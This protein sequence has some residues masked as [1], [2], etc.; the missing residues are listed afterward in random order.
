[1]D[2][3][4]IMAVKNLARTQINVLSTKYYQLVLAIAATVSLIVLLFWRFSTWYYD[5][6]FITYRYAWNLI[7]GL[8]FVYN[9]NERVLSTTTPFF[10][11]LL[12]GFG[13]IWSD[14]PKIASLIGSLCAGLSGFLFW[15]ITRK[16][17]MEIAGWAGLVLIPVFPL[18]TSTI[19]SETPL[20]IA[21][22]LATIDAYI[23]GR[24]RWTAIAAA[25]LILV[26]PDGVLLPLL[27][28]IHFVIWK[29]E[30]LPWQSVGLFVLITALWFGFAWIY[31]GSP[32]PDTLMAKQQQGVMT[33]S[34][35]FAPGLLTIARPYAKSWFYLLEA[36]FALIGLGWL[37]F[38]HQQPLILVAW[39][40]AY[41]LAY[42]LLGVTRYFW[43]YAPLVPAFILMVGSGFQAIYELA[44]YAFRKSR[45]ATFHFESILFIILAVIWVFQGIS[46]YNQSL[47]TDKRVNLYRS[48]GEWLRNNTGQ[49]TRVGAVE[50]GIIG[51][52]AERP[53]V[54]FAGLIQPDV[55]LQMRPDTTYQD[56][57]RWAIR[58][59][60]PDYLAL[61]PV[62]FPDLMKDYVDK[63]CSMLRYFK[64]QDYQSNQDM[65][66]YR[67]H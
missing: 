49:N 5:D 39:A 24:Y 32:L 13:Y 62:I 6:P 4:W 7:H 48:V 38:R 50:V 53:M 61:N 17:K 3:F 11:L 60:K 54:D 35:Q 31:F 47:A 59:Y 8:G 46:T 22:V 30:R 36:F 20:Y 63:R 55:A 27:L 34:Q 15:D 2:Q 37:L 57:A 14:L 9:P 19:S 56:T 66:V 29:K 52:Y 33:I 12:A 42:T 26:R 41:F 21:L 43:Y 10:T 51:Y 1:M 58:Q 23:H 44:I 45:F 25:I 18:I 40:F 28:G 65:A 16:W 67:C 64:A